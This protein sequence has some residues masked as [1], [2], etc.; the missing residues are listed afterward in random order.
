MNEFKKY[1]EIKE[2]KLKNL[3]NIQKKITINTY[4]NLSHVNYSGI[5]QRKIKVNS[6]KKLSYNDC[7]N[8]KY[9]KNNNENLM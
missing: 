6:K 7:L 4:N 3:R 1:L 2:K 8:V 5:N 9:Q